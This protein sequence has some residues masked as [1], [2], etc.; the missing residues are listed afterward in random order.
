[1]PVDERAKSLRLACGDAHEQRAF[2]VLA[3]R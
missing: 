1:M 3:G 2:V